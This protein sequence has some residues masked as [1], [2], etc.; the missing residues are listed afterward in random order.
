MQLFGDKEKGDFSQLAINAVPCQFRE[1]V[2]PYA[3]RD[4]V[5]DDCIKDQDE[6]FKYIQEGSTDIV[7]YHNVEQFQLQDYGE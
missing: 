1:T 6:A 3:E 5:R 2:Y 4:N 7:V